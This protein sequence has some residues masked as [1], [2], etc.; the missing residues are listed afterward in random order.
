MDQAWAGLP[1]PPDSPR[2]RRQLLRE[3]EEL[4]GV[5]QIEDYIYRTDSYRSTSLKHPPP[6]PF[7]TE[8]AYRITANRIETLQSDISDILDDYGL[9]PSRMAGTPVTQRLL[10]PGYPDYSPTTVLRISYRNMMLPARGMGP[11]KDELLGLLRRN[12][13]ADVEVEILDLEKAFRPSLF[14]ISARAPEVIVYKRHKDKIT[15]VLEK[16]LQGAWHTLCLYQVGQNKGK[17]SPTIVVIVEPRT[18]CDWHKL[19]LD[20]R[21]ILPR[22]SNLPVEFLPGGLGDLGGNSQLDRMRDDGTL[23]TGD[24]IT[25][26]GE[27]GGGTLGICAQLKYGA[28]TCSGFL[29]NFHVTRPAGSAPKDIKIK[30]NRHGSSLHVD[31][32]TRTQI[33]Q[34]APWD[35]TET[36]TEGTN[37]AEELKADI[38]KLRQ[39]KYLLEMNGSKVPASIETQIQV[40]QELLA[41]RE[42]KIRV[43]NNMPR[44]IGRVLLSSGA[45]MWRNR[46]LDWAFVELLDNATYE[47]PTF[48]RL[49]DAQNPSRFGLA[50]SYQEGAP[51]AGFGELQENEWYVKVGKATGITDGICNGVKTSCR[52]TTGDSVRYDLE[53]NKLLVDPKVTEEFVVLNEVMDQVQVGYCK[54]G[55]SGSVL[56]SRKGE[57]CGLLYGSTHTY[58]GTGLN[59]YA[60]LA[61]T[62]PDVMETL[63]VRSL[64]D[65]D[66]F[67]IL[68]PL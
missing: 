53:G 47:P 26:A 21:E 40:Y 42:Q 5:M 13:I 1:T 23:Q 38:R 22:A 68:E 62:M 54:P 57:I 34:F 43:A 20:L 56:L 24:S 31:D 55:D 11:A 16:T 46:V 27:N 7:R 9:P 2:K 67:A 51:L 36:V 15:E 49:S 33:V 59:V 39:R 45:T 65:D 35:I 50:L 63:K 19:M 8:S 58:G 30:A 29:T 64:G 6:L 37:Y 18:T 61:M 14:A 28:T 12:G 44:D 4:F 52:W 25:V 17:A 66:R 41:G 32:E 10:E 60:G 48:P 3:S